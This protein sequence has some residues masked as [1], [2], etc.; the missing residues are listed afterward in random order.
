[1]AKLFCLSLTTSPSDGT[2]TEHVTLCIIS[3]LESFSPLKGT[4]GE[5][6]GKS[7]YG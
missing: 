6:I 4:R 2:K 5:R 3:M 1:M 7:I